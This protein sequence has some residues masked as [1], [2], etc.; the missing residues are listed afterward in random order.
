MA[1]SWDMKW[2]H[3]TIMGSK[4]YLSST[5]IV[6]PSPIQGKK[7]WFLGHVYPYMFQSTFRG[8]YLIAWNSWDTIEDVMGLLF[9]EYSHN[10]ATQ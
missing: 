9:I 8:Y 6:N 7:T 1:G 3:G 2:D 10:I 5:L 4:C